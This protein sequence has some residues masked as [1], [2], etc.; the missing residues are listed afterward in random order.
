MTTPCVRAADCSV[1]TP[2]PSSEIGFSTSTCLPA[3]AAFSA[4]STCIECGSG[5]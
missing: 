2:A 3:W 5:M 1:R 4:H